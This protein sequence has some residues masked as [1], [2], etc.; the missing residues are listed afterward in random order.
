MDEVAA[1][2]RSSKK[3]ALLLQRVA[4]MTALRHQDDGTNLFSSQSGISSPHTVT[5][6]ASHSGSRAFSS[7]T[8]E[9]ALVLSLSSHTGINNS[10]EW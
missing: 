9:C 10:Y 2:V 4:A 6:D 8:P 5:G 1:V 3:S 7:L